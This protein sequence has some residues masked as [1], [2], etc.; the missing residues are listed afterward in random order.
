MI[1]GDPSK[2]AVEAVPEYVFGR[3]LA[4]RMRVFLQG[5]AVGSFEEPGC[6]L[7]AVCDQLVSR[8]LIRSDLWHRSLEGLT[9]RE[10]FELLDGA[11]YIGSVADV[12][13]EYHSM[14]FLTGASEAF[15]RVKAFLVN[16][17]AGQLVCLIEL[18]EADEFFSCAVDL[19]EFSTVAN[20]FSA[21]VREQL[22]VYIARNGA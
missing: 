20:Q 11:L 3:T 22:Q 12:P 21:W 6:A 14:N 7:N 13:P 1:I 15:D 2:I 8:A 18:L 5:R 19:A 16:P 4:G 17:G 9:P 10:Q